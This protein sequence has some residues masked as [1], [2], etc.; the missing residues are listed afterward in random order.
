[1][2]AIT[3]SPSNYKFAAKTQALINGSTQ[4]RKE[5]YYETL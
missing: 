5:C 1:M 4:T 2:R 3:Q